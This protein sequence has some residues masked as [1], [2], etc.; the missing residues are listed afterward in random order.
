[1]KG[2]PVFGVE[3]IHHNYQ[4]KRRIGAT[5]WVYIGGGGEISYPNAGVKWDFIEFYGGVS[6]EELRR[7][8]RGCERGFGVF[9]RICRAIRKTLS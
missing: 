4:T 7:V 3:T 1:M 5:F 2:T 8:V 6:E 9:E